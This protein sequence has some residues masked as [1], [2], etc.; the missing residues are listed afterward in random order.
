MFDKL[1]SNMEAVVWDGV[2][3]TRE[4]WENNFKDRKIISEFM[5][6]SELGLKRLA[7]MPDRTTNTVSLADGSTA[8]VGGVRVSV[9]NVH[10]GVSFSVLSPSLLPPARGR[11]SDFDT[12]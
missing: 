12:A 8:C 11:H 5:K 1:A 7:S 9:C 3:E 10:C 4:Q 2:A 6:D